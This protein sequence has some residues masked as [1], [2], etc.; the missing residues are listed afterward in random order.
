MDLMLSFIVTCLIVGFVTAGLKIR[1]DRFFAMILLFNLIGL[2]INQSVDIFLWIV[3]LGSLYIIIEN[4]SSINEMPKNA[5]IHFF[6]TIPIVTFASAFVGSYLFSL[7]PT[8]I[9]VFSLGIIALIYG[10]RLVFIHFKAHECNYQHEE[11]LF[12]KF[13]RYFGPVISGLSLGFIGTS[14]KPLK[15]PVCVKYGKMNLNQVYIGNTIIA[16]FSS[17]FALMWHHLLK[18]PANSYMFYNIF[19]NFLFGASLWVAIH[20]IYELTN[21]FFKDSWRKPFQILIGIILI[22]IS[23]KFFGT[24]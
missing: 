20:Y 1:F 2:S 12:V 9:L 7:S 23:F 24:V 8:F 14:L 17:L 18:S 16:F 5:R 19:Y 6:I 13:D 3:L 15:I 10:L 11:T 22:I 4:R 21:L